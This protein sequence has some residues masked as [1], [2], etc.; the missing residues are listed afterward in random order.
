MKTIFTIILVNF[1]LFA[2]AQ[3]SDILWVPEQKSLIVSQRPNY[4]PVGWYIGGFYTTSFPAPFIYTTPFSIINRIGLNYVGEN[5]KVSIMGGVFFGQEQNELKFKPD[6]WLKI[7]P[8]RILT[9]TSKGFDFT[10]GVNYM[11]R[12]R[13]GFG[14]SIP[15][16]GIY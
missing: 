7:Y 11:D 4:S 3:V 9:N 14:I 13:F 12:I 5:Q 16:R 8:L 6:V 10:V 2:N 15:S 1:Y